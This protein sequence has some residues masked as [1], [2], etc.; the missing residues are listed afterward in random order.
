M[1]PMRISGALHYFRVHPDQWATRLGWLRHLG[2]D[3]VETYVPWNLHEPRPGEHRFDGIADLE[4]FLAEVAA[5]SR[6]RHHTR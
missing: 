3:T 6:Q 4:R 1:K 5:A 2:L